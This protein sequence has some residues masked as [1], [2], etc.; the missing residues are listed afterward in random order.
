M[1]LTT[2]V[3]AS[4]LAL[5]GC[6]DGDPSR[7]VKPAP[8]PSVLPQTLV[9]SIGLSPA[10]L[11]KRSSVELIRNGD[12]LEGEPTLDECGV[13]FQSEAHRVARHQV[14]VHFAKSLPGTYSNEV[15]AY[16]SPESAELALQEWRRAVQDCNEDE[17][18][19]SAVEGVPDVKVRLQEFHTLESLPVSNNAVA[20]QLV[21]TRAGNYEFLSIVMQQQ[22][23]VL[24][25]HYLTTARQPRRRQ[26]A[27][28]TQQAR[29]TGAR[30]VELANGTTT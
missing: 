22:G 8:K 2:I 25:A 7:E 26:V 17:F 18:H 11:P 4:L 5:T 30:L 1:R 28:L 3:L 12:Q 14:D 24:D 29:A 20:R 6:T 16:D 23:T 19:P 9:E 10:D 15:V 27:R 13:V 21:V